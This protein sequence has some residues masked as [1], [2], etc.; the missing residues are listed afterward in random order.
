MSQNLFAVLFGWWPAFRDKEEAAIGAAAEALEPQAK[1][2]LISAAKAGASAALSTEGDT[3]VKGEAA[4]A[5]AGAVLE[6]A[7]QQIA[8]VLIQAAIQGEISAPQVAP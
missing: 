8:P 5:A 1:Q 7:G 3:K 6:T 2:A 4:L